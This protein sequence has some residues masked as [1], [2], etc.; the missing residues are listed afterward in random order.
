MEL[1]HVKQIFVKEGEVRRILKDEVVLWEKQEGILITDF[2]HYRYATYTIPIPVHE[3]PEPE[4]DSEI[5]NEGTE[6]EEEPEELT[7]VWE[8]SELP[9]GLTYKVTSEGLTFSG[10]AEKIQR[11]R[12]T[13]KVTI[14]EYTEENL[15]TFDI[16]SD[17]N[18]IFI[19]N[20]NLGVWYNG[21]SGVKSGAAVLSISGS[22]ASE[23]SKVRYYCSGTPSWMN[24]DSQNGSIVGTPNDG[25]EAQS[26]YVTVYA[27][28]GGVNK[29]GSYK[30]PNKMLRW[31]TTNVTPRFRCT[32]IKLDCTADLRATG[33][34]YTFFTLDLS[35]Y[36]YPIETGLNDITYTIDE[37][38]G[39]HVTPSMWGN[40]LEL[41]KKSRCTTT[42]N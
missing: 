19:A 17:G 20:Q 26:G 22:G 6:P 30:T 14:G 18:E 31:R 2:K 5:V 24:I 39:K 23:S 3:E 16:T 1:E 27:I 37:T 13:V 36:Y 21:E 35:Q 15:Y 34:K 11:K 9:Q 42:L 38:Q 10:Y 12:V 32:K 8:I 4:E 41:Y 40:K 7:P 28:R 33:T 29:V 25:Y